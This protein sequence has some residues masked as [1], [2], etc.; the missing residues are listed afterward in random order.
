MEVVQTLW[1]KV[2]VTTSIVGIFRNGLKLRLT[3]KEDLAMRA[4]L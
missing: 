4:R 3:L 2:C 1:A